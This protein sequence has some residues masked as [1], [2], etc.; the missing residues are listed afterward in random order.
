[1]IELAVRL[2]DR[3]RVEGGVTKS[4]LRQAM[5]GRVPAAVLDRRDKLGFAAPQRAW[6]TAGHAEV[7]DILRGGQIVERGWVG[8]EEVERHLEDGLSGGRATEHLWR[9]FI[10]EAW[11]RMQWPDES[12]T[13]GRSTW[14]AATAMG[15]ADRP[16]GTAT[17]VVAA[18]PS[19]S[20]SIPGEGA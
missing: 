6:L 17:S 19:P 16:G 9:L 7:A 2:P 5:R 20:M 13:T 12:G 18:A 8:Q 10:T 15:P 11:L 1:L 3:L 14:E 4:V